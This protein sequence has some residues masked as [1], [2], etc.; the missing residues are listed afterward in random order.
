MVTT[1]LASILLLS[2]WPS[3]RMSTSTPFNSSMPSSVRSAAPGARQTPAT[4]ESVVPEAMPD[5]SRGRSTRSLGSIA[6]SAG[7][8]LQAARRRRRRGA[9]PVRSAARTADEARASQLGPFI[10]LDP[11]AHP[12]GR[13]LSERDPCDFDVACVIRVAHT[14]GC[15]LEL[16][17]Q[18]NGSILPARIAR[19]RRRKACSF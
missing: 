6:R 14:R 10:P 2:C 12:T 7:R 13:P 1:M 11:R 5:G 3:S 18:P 8:H 9:Q 15:Y 17:A 16:N 19:W 4:S